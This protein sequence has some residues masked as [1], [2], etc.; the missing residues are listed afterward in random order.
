M[1]EQAPEVIEWAE[2]VDRLEAGA[3][4]KLRGIK[5]ISPT[6]EWCELNGTGQCREDALAMWDEVFGHRYL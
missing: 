4:I 2:R 3:V 6:R 5:C 1:T